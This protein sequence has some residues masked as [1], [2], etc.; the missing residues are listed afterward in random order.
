MISLYLLDYEWSVV[1]LHAEGLFEAE[2][3]DHPDQAHHQAKH[4][5]PEGTLNDAILLHKF[6]KGQ[7][8]SL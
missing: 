2:V 3:Q 6:P 8:L 7:L 4:E 1:H 5:A